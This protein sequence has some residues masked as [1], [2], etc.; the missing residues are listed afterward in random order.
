[1][2]ARH[3]GVTALWI[4]LS[5]ARVGLGLIAAFPLGLGLALAQQP[6]PPPCQ[7]QL[8]QALQRSITFQQVAAQEREAIA[9]YFQ[10]ELRKLTEERN[11]LQRRLDELKP[12]AAKEP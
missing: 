11:E 12:Q 8:A 2:S 4:G 1:M 5:C 7:V 10:E 3:Q 9:Q 6:P